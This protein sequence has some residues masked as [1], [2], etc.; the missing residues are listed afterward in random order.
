LVRLR[1]EARWRSSALGRVDYGIER[2]G[3]IRTAIELPPGT[4]PSQVA[5]IGFECLVTT[6]QREQPPP[7]SGTCRVREVSKA[8]FL[9]RDYRPG[10][11][12]W[13]MKTP[14]E[15]PSGQVLTWTLK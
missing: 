9:E 1:E 7:V 12:F 2:D 4:A 13:Q 11:S 14:V 3:W 10:T 5:E 15:I 8:F 6:P